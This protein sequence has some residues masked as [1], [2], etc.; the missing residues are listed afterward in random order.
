MFY[1]QIVVYFDKF[2]ICAKNVVARADF[3]DFAVVVE[4]LAFVIIP[5]FSLDFSLM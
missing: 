4:H 1:A 2:C 5:V 3:V